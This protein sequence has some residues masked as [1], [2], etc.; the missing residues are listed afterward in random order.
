MFGDILLA[1]PSGGKLF[2]SVAGAQA[3]LITEAP[4]EITKVLS[5]PARQV[6][7]LG[8]NEEA[9]GTFN[10]RCIRWCDI[11][12]F[13]DWTTA[14]DNNAGEYILSGQEDIVSGCVLGQYIPIWTTGSLWLGQYLGEPGQTYEFTRIAETGIVAHGAYAIHKGTVYWMD[15]ALNVWEYAPG[16]LP[17]Q[18][19]CPVSSDLIGAR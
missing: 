18:I 14:S 12:D 6:M 10:G 19:P 17:V 2:K 16:T 5:V 3:E 15:Q 9:S 13:T 11:E 1:S 4:T 7:A 8:C